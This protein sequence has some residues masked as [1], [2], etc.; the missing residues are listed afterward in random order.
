M[1][2]PETRP[3]GRERRRRTDEEGHP[4]ASGGRP[5]PRRRRLPARAGEAWLGPGRTVHA[6]GQHRP[7]PRRSPSSTASSCARAPRC[8]RRSPSTPARRSWRPSASRDGRRDQPGRGPDRQRGRLPEGDAWW[9]GNLSLTWAYDP[10]DRGSRRPRARALR[11]PARPTWSTRES[12]SSSARR[13]RGS[14]R[15][16]SRPSGQ[17]RPACP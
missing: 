6:R 9:P 7:T 3:T 13:S 11:P 5:R 17:R 12:T 1:G 2:A 10:A 4:R 14:A 15:R 8:S 16:S